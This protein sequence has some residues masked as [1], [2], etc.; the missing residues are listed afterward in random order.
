MAQSTFYHIF[1]ICAHE[2]Y[3]QN[4]ARE[5]IDIIISI[6]IYAASAF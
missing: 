4:Q 1:F 2:I 6:W 3:V 5:I